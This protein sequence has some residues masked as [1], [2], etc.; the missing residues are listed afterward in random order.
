MI[1]AALVAVAVQATAPD[2]TVDP[3]Y[4]EHLIELAGARIVSRDPKAARYSIELVTGE[5][6][7]LFAGG[8]HHVAWEAEG[9]APDPSGV[10]ELGIRMSRLTGCPIADETPLRLYV[11]DD[12]QQLGYVILDT[13]NPLIS[14]RSLTA[15][16]SDGPTPVQYRCVIT[17]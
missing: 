8:C 11:R 7:T 10:A 16:T 3:G 15:A 13:R 14:E 2:C 6:I 5:M 9:V 12:L 1:A 4:P 17:P